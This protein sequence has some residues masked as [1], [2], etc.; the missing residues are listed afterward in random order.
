MLASLSLRTGPCREDL[1][2]AVMKRLKPVDGFRVAIPVL[3][4]SIK[5][6]VGLRTSRSAVTQFT[7]RALSC[8]R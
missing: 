8:N 7:E 3:V 2:L 1:S 5:F 4:V 6:Q